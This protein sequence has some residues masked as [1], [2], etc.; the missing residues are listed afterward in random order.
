[1]LDSQ[2]LNVN[3]G[4]KSTISRKRLNRMV[5]IHTYTTHN[6]PYASHPRL[7]SIMCDLTLALLIH[8]LF[9]VVP[10]EV[11]TPTK[12]FFRYCLAKHR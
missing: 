4:Q 3:Q 10:K 7:N 12:I 11:A 1:M 5:A 9:H 8:V 2:F 6:T